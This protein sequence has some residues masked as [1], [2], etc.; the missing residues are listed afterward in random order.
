MTL[1]TQEELD[2]VIAHFLQ[3]YPEWA[4]IGNDPVG[5]KEMCV[6]SSHAFLAHVW[7]MGVK[8]KSIWLRLYGE[9]PEGETHP[10]ELYPRCS[11]RPY[12]CVV[13]VERFIVDLTA[14]QYSASLPFPFVWPA[15]AGPK[16]FP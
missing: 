7:P 4:E 16:R 14:K 1:E 2:E 15:P 5:S 13:K 10:H 8:A 3:V 12:H 9:T 11:R 6:A